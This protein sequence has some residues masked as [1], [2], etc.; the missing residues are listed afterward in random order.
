M[1]GKSGK[2]VDQGIGDINIPI[3][4]V[5]EGKERGIV[6]RENGKSGDSKSGYDCIYEVPMIKQFFKAIWFIEFTVPV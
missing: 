4:L 1:E 3:M 6:N 5:F 2:T